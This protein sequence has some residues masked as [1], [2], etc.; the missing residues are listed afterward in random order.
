MFERIRNSE[1]L[2]SGR[3]IAASVIAGFLFI[4]VARNNIFSAVIVS[5]LLWWFVWW[6][7][8]AIAGI[9]EGL[10][11]GKPPAV[12]VGRAWQSSGAKMQ[13]R[14]DANGEVFGDCG[15]ILLRERYWFVATGTPPIR[16][17]VEEYQRAVQ[18]QEQEPVLI[19]T[20][21][22][23]NFWWYDNAIYWTNNWDYDS[24]DIKALLFAR[25][26]QRQRE[27]DHAHALMAAADSPAIRKREPIPRDVK[28]AVFE[29][30]AGRC[31]E[32]GSNFEIQYDHII[33]FSMNGANT[34]ENLQLLCARCNQRKGGRL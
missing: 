22:D 24:Q 5:T 28:Q 27:L 11:E 32:C 12:A 4:G 19:A 25:E 8:G 7:A 20:H 9:W 2:A 18:Q 6:F 10:V 17:S 29:R 23:R 14:E 21:R 26:R 15:G 34:V 33:P 3:G 1:R 16:L 31:I 13:L 30:D